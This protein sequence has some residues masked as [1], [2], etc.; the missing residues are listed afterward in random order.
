MSESQQTDQPSYHPIP[1]PGLFI[2]P[3]PHPPHLGSAG[4]PEGA[5]PADPKL[6]DLHDKEQQQSIQEESQ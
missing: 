6:Q 5:G 4:A 3:P 1:E 2:S